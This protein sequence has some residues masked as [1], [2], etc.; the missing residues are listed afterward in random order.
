[1]G[2]RVT[3]F[4]GCEN[5]RCPAHGD[6][7]PGG[8]K[9]CGAT[10]NA[11]PDGSEREPIMDHIGAVCV[12]CARHMGATFPEWISAPYGTFVRSAG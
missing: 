3:T 5:S 1:M 4:C 12:D 7:S 2:V 6:G 10:V 8:F 11:D 9:V